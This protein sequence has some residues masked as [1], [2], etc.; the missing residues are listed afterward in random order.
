MDEKDKAV[1]KESSHKKPV[2][3]HEV[4]F[5][6]ETGCIHVERNEYRFMNMTWEIS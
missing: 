6:V 3:W 1:G 4:N 5:S 2:G